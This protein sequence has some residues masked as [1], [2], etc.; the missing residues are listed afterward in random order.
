MNRIILIGNGFDLAH[1]LKTS[2]A[3]FIDWYWKEWGERLLHGMNKIEEDGLVSFR[4]N[5]EAVVI[6]WADVWDYVFRREDPF[7]PWDVNLVL[8]LAK[9]NNDICDFII[10]SPILEELCK[11]LND[12]KW[13]D[14]ENVFFRHLSNDNEKPKK[15]NF[16]L[17]V[18]RNRLID[19]LKEV[20]DT[21]S[22]EVVKKDVQNKMLEPFNKKDMAVGSMDKWKEMLQQRVRYRE[23]TWPELIS[24]C[25]SNDKVYNECN[26]VDNF[27][28][29]YAERIWEFGIDSID[30][31]RVPI[32][33]LL[34]ERVMMLNFNYTNIADSYLPINERFNVNHIHGKLTS[35]ESVIFGYGDEMDENYKKLSNKNDNEY[36]TNIKSIKYLESPNYRNLLDFIESD[37]YQ[38]YIMGHS[39]GNSDRTLLNTLF[40]HK[41]CVSIKPFYFI[42]KDGTDNYMELVQNISRNFTDMKL[43]RDR[44]VNKEFCE[45]YSDLR[46]TAS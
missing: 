22:G 29:R 8:E 14:I 27:L 30:D 38:L 11:Q 15:V 39:C 7:K 18:I 3:D 46:K 43:M 2:Y 23:D 24:L 17:S 26:N 21:V 31:D 40:E 19:Y 32:G 9:T 10:T 34:P 12:R 35:P 4:L 25:F 44:V 42:R 20:Q 13:V 37:T 28:K 45:P 5:K 33:L 6:K 41:N 36:L 16:E 1:G